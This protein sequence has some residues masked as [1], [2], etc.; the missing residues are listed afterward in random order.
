MTIREQLEEREA[1]YLSQYAALSRNTKGRMRDEPQCDIRPG[2]LARLG[3]LH[4][5]MWVP[6]SPPDQCSIEHNGLHKPIP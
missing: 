4:D 3:H 6:D 5:K 2:C 1:R